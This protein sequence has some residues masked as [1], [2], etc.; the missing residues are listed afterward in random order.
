MNLIKKSKNIE[1]VY[2]TNVLEISGGEKLEKIML[3][4][5]YNG[6]KELKIDG[7][8]IEIGS[9]PD[10]DYTGGMEIETDSDGY[11]KI[12][13]KGETSVAG[14]WAAGDITDGS[15]KFRQVIT[16]AAEGA[17]AAR[18]VFN[19]LKKEKIQNG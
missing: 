17:I 16:A 13:S 7:L 18:G 1:V 6:E 3:N 9:D 14:I 4:K 19:W 11:V 10:I 12:S 15:D 2:D 5:G 8:F